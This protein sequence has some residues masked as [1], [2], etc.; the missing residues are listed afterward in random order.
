MA[1]PH[2]ADG[3]DGL[4]IWRVAVNILNKQLRTADRERYSSLG[5]GRGF[6][7]H[8][9]GTPNL[10]RKKTRPSDQD[11]FFDKTILTQKNGHEIW[12]L[13]S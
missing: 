6:T 13:E 1:R 10:L 11:G 7:T 4:Q 5:V 9:R 8:H 12:H 2:V 3:G